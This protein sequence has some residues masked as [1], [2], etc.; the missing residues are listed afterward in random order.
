MCFNSNLVTELLRLIRY[1]ELYARSAQWGFITRDHN[2]VL[3]P[4][5]HF[6]LRLR[7]MFI[8]SVVLEATARRKKPI[9]N[10]PIE[11]EM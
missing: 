5:R 11:R 6:P 10:Q 1:T 2:A 4:H 9:A 3:S 8:G 7:V